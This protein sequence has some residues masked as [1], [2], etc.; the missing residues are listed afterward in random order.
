MALADHTYP[1]RRHDSNDLT[2]DAT[3]IIHDLTKSVRQT[4]VETRGPSQALMSGLGR[5]KKRDAASFRGRMIFRSAFCFFHCVLCPS[6]TRVGV[7]LA[8]GAGCLG[9]SVRPS[10]AKG[11][12]TPIDGPGV[13][14][15]F[16]SPALLSCKWQR[17]GTADLSKRD[18]EDTGSRVCIW[19]IIREPLLPVLKIHMRPY[20]PA[21]MTTAAS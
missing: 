19:C 4:I 16:L 2:R 6:V 14:E 17:W 18:S 12:A 10:R 8:G 11:P 15:M 3:G 20:R 1:L 5:E 9:P 21:T 13:Q 7:S